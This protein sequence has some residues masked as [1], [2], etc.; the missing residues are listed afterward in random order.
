MFDVTVPKPASAVD[1]KCNGR[2]NQLMS[3][4]RDCALSY[5]KR[6]VLHVTLM[7]GARLYESSRSNV[8]KGGFQI[9]ITIVYLFCF[10]VHC[11]VI[12]SCYEMYHT[13]CR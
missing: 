6:A 1:E 3:Y 10:I 5:M 2:R 9:A 8:G 4:T 11:C 12:V 7:A 13:V